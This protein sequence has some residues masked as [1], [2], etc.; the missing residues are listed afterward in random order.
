LDRTL[1]QRAIGNLIENAIDHTPPGG[2]ATV[3]AFRDGDALCV[4]VSDTGCGIPPEHVPHV[5][6]RFYRVEASRSTKS[7]RLGLGLALVKGIVA[8]HCGT[9]EIQSETGRGTDVTLRVPLGAPAA[10]LTLG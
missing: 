9:V 10:H 4:Q 5:F 6:D 1:W 8:L 2:H 3:K 7:G